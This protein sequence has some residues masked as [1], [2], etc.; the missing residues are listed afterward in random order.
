MAN[1]NQ[2]FSH[3]TLVPVDFSD[4]AMMA[5]DHAIAVT[6]AINEGNKLITLLHV[7]EGGQFHTV[8]ES[9]Q[10]DAASRD[11]LAIEGAINRLKSVIENYNK[12]GDIGFKYIV[13]SGKPYRKIS[14]IAEDINADLIVM[15]THGSSGI[16]AFA[17]SNASKVIQTAHCPV[18]SVKEKPM[19]GDYQN[20]VLPLDLTR[21]T[22]QKVKI[23]AMIARFFDATVHILSMNESDEFLASKLKK[24]MAQVSKYFQDQGVKTS[25]TILS[26]SD[27]ARQAIVWAQGKDADL[28]IIMAQ[29]DRGFSEFIFGSTAQQ[30]VNRSPVPVMTVRPREDLAAILGRT[31]AAAH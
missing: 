12:I 24:N 20:I 15:G 23:A 27:F 11:S 28:I 25:T 22:K 8:S 5:L 4:T 31:E 14:E 10:L 21:E 2:E 6:K 7:I 9:S 30:I 18:I 3:T 29:Q 19:Q 16:Q 17:G 1:N 13:A 26:S